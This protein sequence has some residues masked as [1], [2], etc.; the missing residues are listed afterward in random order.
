M[1]LCAALCLAQRWVELDQKHML[2][3]DW[4]Q[5]RQHPNIPYLQPLVFDQA[6]RRKERE[7][8]ERGILK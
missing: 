5:R 6:K 8:Y 2:L 7:L 1:S 4:L 3:P